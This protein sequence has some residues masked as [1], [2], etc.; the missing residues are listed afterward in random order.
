MPGIFGI[1]SKRPKMVNENELALMQKALN[2]DNLYSTGKYIIESQSIYL[3]WT[4]HKNSFSDCLP[5]VNETNDLVLIYY[6]ENFCDP[7][8]FD[9]LKRAHHRFDRNNCSY[10]LHMYEEWG[11]DFLLRLNGIFHGVIIDIINEEIIIFNDRYGLQTINY[12]EG[13]DAYY[14]AAEAKGI[15]ALQDNIRD[16]DVKSLSET[17]T[18]DYVLDNKTLFKSI[19]KFDAGTYLVF[20]KNCRSKKIKY[21]NHAELEN[22]TFLE[23]EFYLERLINTLHKVL[24][25]YFRSDDKIGIFLQ[26]DLDCMILLA[27]AQYGP[28]KLSCYTFNFNHIPGYNID[29]VKSIANSI[30][31]NLDIL[32]IGDDFILNYH[33]MLTRSIYYSECNLAVRSSIDF[34]ANMLAREI[35][36]I[37]ISYNCAARLLRNE[38]FS[39][40]NK[41]NSDLFC[42]EFLEIDVSA[43]EREFETNK[44]DLNFYLEKGIAYGE[45]AKLMLQQSQYTVRLPFLDNDFIKMLYRSPVEALKNNELSIRMCK[46]K[47]IDLKKNH[48]KNESNFFISTLKKMFYKNNHQT[49]LHKYYDQKFKIRNKER[50]D[51]YF[52][53]ILM[54]QKTLNRPFINKSFFQNRINQHFNGKFDFSDDI[55]KL[56]SI[57]LLYRTFID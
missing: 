26:E 56:L 50:I 23:K 40:I 31:Q 29:S 55:T 27:N 28:R 38:S 57:E 18:L 37:H 44:N 10:I 9:Q 11:K 2:S 19:F 3:G 22:Q 35:A 51:N 52:K 20:D 33:E 43:H 1:I 34:Y 4:C 41:T 32:T 16:I 36:P 25:R 42:R 53:E 30:D 8:L 39:K 14:F 7:E 46:N 45:C 15:L 5:V 48:L 54:D 24:K 49:N 6:G 13:N 12:Y 21:F 17:L 47:N